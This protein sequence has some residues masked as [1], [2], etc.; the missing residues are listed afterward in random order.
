MHAC[1]HPSFLPSFLHSFI[2]SFIHS[3]IHPFTHSFIHS[4]IHLSIHLFLHSFFPSFIQLFIP[5]FFP[6]FVH[7]CIDCFFQFI[8]P[9]CIDF[10]H[11]ISLA[12]Q[13]QFAR[14]IRWCK[15]QPQHF[16]ASAS[17][18]HSYSHRFFIVM[19]VFQ[20]FLP[21]TTGHHWQ[22]YG[23]IK[24][25]QQ[26]S[27]PNNETRKIIAVAICTTEWYRLTLHKV[28]LLWQMSLKNG[29]GLQF[30]SN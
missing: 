9:L 1:M 28:T 10:F 29:S 2:L 8:Q 18:R 19:S 15:S 6:S 20:N 26:Q 30:C 5:C 14:P 11:V 13:Q 16:I 24:K 7:S 17:P 4:S 12:S 21:S 27:Q 3:F 25:R 22:S 23:P